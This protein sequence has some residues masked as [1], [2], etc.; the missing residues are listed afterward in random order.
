MNL[1][2]LQ[3]HYPEL[4]LYMEENGYSREYIAKIRT[5]I[6]RVLTETEK[7]GWTSYAEVYEDYAKKLKSSSNLRMKLTSLGIIEHFDLHGHYPNP[8]LFMNYTSTAI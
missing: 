3:K 7:E 2:R 8:E 5:V 6:L 4:L 1:Q